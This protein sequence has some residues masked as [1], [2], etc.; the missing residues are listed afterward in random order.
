MNT[1]E[2]KKEV[3]GK[4]KEDFNA[5]GIKVLGE[6]EGGNEHVFILWGDTYKEN[7]CSDY[8]EMIKETKKVLLKLTFSP[9]G[10]YVEVNE[11]L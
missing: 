11:V 1:E 6:Y 3:I 4:L 5:F 10:Y 7:E 2:V 9:N 8:H